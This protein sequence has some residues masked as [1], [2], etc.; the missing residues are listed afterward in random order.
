M[1]GEHEQVGTSTEVG[2]FFFFGAVFKMM[3][4]DGVHTCIYKKTQWRQ[5]CFIGS[6]AP[7]VTVSEQQNTQKKTEH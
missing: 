5:Y 6:L 3:R 2:I 7:M 1:A 4:D